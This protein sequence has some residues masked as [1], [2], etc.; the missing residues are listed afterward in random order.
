[1]FDAFSMRARQVVFA[2]RFKAGERGADR[3]EID[4]FL[5]G[6]IL[7]DQNMIGSLMEDAFPGIRQGATIVRESPDEAHS[8]FFAPD[9]ADELLIRMEISSP[10]RPP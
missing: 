5:L 8:Q 7:E 2:A 1:M 9:S 6:L 4:D 10:A 3:I